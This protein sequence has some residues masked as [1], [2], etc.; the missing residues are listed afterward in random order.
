[1][2]RTCRQLFEDMGKG[3]R[4]CFPIVIGFLVVA[5]LQIWGA[6]S[7]FVTASLYTPTCLAP[8]H[9]FSTQIILIPTTGFLEGFYAPGPRKLPPKQQQQTQHHNDDQ[10]S[11]TLGGLQPVKTCSLPY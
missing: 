11:I 6:E 9:F 1:M 2:V 8:G 7:T 4:I 10:T 3:R 5:K